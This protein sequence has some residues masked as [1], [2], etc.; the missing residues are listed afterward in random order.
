MCATASQAGLKG[1]PQTPRLFLDGSR[2]GVVQEI[3]LY[4]T[5]VD[6][7]LELPVD[8][9]GLQTSSLQLCCEG[10]IDFRYFEIGLDPQTFQTFLVTKNR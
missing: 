1:L 5:Q 8:R 9:A 7:Q 6:G 2:I 10:L 3:Y 4:G